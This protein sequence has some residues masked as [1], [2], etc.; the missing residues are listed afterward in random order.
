MCLL[1]RGADGECGAG[2]REAGRSASDRP[3]RKLYQ[4]FGIAFTY[5]ELAVDPREP[6]KLTEIIDSYGSVPF[7]ILPLTTRVMA[8]MIEDAIVGNLD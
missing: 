7:R 3:H 4:E 8:K 2:D 6:A 1:R 5:G